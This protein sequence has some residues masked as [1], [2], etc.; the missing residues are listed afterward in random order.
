VYTIRAACAALAF[1]WTTPVAAQVGHA[2]EASPYRDVRVKT[3]LSITG[4]YTSGSG[5]K[6]GVGPAKGPT[7]GARV[8]LLLGGPAMLGVSVMGG[9]LA[10]K[11]ID[12]SQP[13]ESREVGESSQRILFVEGSVG[14]VFTGRKTWHGLAPYLGGSLGLGIG[15]DVAA[16]SLSDFEYN[17]KFTAALFLGVRWHVGQRVALRIEVRN[18][19]WQLRYPDSFFDTSDPTNPPV[20]DPLVNGETEWTHNP[21]LWV[22]LGYAIRM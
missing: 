21:Q 14:L 13:P 5:G 19:M 6:V 1:L 22:S 12:P 9:S 4:G 2:P 11:L 3:L 10:R 20:L 18:M 17:T 16:D 8:D 7:G 15:G